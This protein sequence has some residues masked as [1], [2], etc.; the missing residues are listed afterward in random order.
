MAFLV[1]TLPSGA[2]DTPAAVKRAIE[3]QLAKYRQAVLAKDTATALSIFSEDFSMSLPN[4]AQRTAA[5]SARDLAEFIK[6]TRSIRDWKMTVGPVK[7]EN[8]RA[9]VE[10]QESSVRTIVTPEG[11]QQTQGERSVLRDRWVKVRQGA[12][13][14][15]KLDWIDLKSRVVTRDPR[16]AVDLLTKRYEFFRSACIARDIPRA[17]LVWSKDYAEEYPNGMLLRRNQA[18][19]FLRRTLGQIV[20]TPKW[21]ITLDRTKGA[22]GKLRYDLVLRDDVMVVR[23][24]DRIVANV[25]G[26]KGKVF[27]QTVEQTYKDTWVN[28]GQGWKWRYSE[29]ISAK[30]VVNGKTYFPFGPPKSQRA[31]A[32]KH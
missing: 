4:G 31:T 5:Q 15:W 12:S 13:W 3:S 32:A 21:T 17:I 29:T 19:E 2:K 20:G 23:R 22:D 7:L 8:N 1:V 28:E 16:P 18:E 14:V 26:A 30:N 24:T 11:S 6:E 27:Q 9:L 25:K 10:V